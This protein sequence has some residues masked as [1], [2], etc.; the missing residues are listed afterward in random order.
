MRSSRRQHASLAVGG[1]GS[2]A[3][4]TRSNRFVS[5]TFPSRLSES[6]DDLSLLSPSLCV[7]LQSAPVGV[8]HLAWIEAL[9]NVQRRSRAPLRKRN[10]PCLQTAPAYRTGYVVTA[11]PPCRLDRPRHA[12]FPRASTEAARTREPGARTTT[13]GQGAWPWRI[14]RRRPPSRRPC[15][16][17]SGFLYISPV[18]QRGRSPGRWGCGRRGRCSTA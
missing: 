17:A 3:P 7:V 12:L 9:G 13:T 6:E 2:A 15:L 14:S 16:P 5:G 4:R 11:I 18:L 10:D 1:D 8:I